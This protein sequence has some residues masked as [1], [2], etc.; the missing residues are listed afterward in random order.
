VV[1]PPIAALEDW[2]VWAGT[3][4]FIITETNTVD[5]ASSKRKVSRWVAYGD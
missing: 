3:I 2:Y 5:C 1:T 4:S